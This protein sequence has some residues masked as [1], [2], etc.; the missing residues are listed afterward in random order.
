MPPKPSISPRAAKDCY[1]SQTAISLSIAKMEEELGFLLF[2]RNNRSMRLTPAG[3]DFHEWAVQTL[4]SYEK[5]VESGRNIA[6]GYTGLIRI[7][8]SSTFEALWFIPQ[9]QSFRRRFA[10][11][12]I[13]QR[14]MDAFS[15]VHAL[16]S[17]DVDAVVAPPYEYMDYKNTSIQELAVFPMI[18]VMCKKHPLA[19]YAQAPLSALEKHT[20]LIL[21]YQNQL[22]SEKYFLESARDSGIR[23]RE[24]RQMDSL[25]EIMLHLINSPDVPFCPR[26]S[27]AI[28]T[29]SLWPGPCR[30]APCAWPSPLST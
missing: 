20:T 19:K 27:P 3:R 9:L 1:I 10:D 11:V 25:D 7:G 5:A 8:F 15:L 6:S 29:T 24:L 17:R 13:E 18:L 28:S 23:F 21:S 22:Q 12:H 30:T 4:H 14:I 26:S 2:E 16:Q